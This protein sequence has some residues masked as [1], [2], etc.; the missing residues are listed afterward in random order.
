VV[1]CER[2]VGFGSAC[3]RAVSALDP[4]VEVVCLHNPDATVSA[5]AL[6]ELA[7]RV[8]PDVGAVAPALQ[9]GTVIRNNGYHYPSPPREAYLARRGVRRSDAPLSAGRARRRLPTQD[10]RRFGS[11]ALLVVSRR[12]FE[13]IDGFDERYFMYGEDLDLWHRLELS[14]YEN[15]FCPSVIALHDR[16]TG[17][18]MSRGKREI[19]RW[20]GVELFAQTH[21][22]TGWKPYRIIHRR[23]LSRVDVRSEVGACIADAW[24]QQLPPSDVMALVT[25][26]LQGDA[27][28][29]E[30]AFR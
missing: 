4:S 7:T 2:N 3:N 8:R 14:G 16:S 10:R 15:V 21:L 30:D 26:V 22:R 5:A 9:I 25:P 17:S 24:R 18:P 20:L 19:L 11:G 1:R 23:L 28:D 13:Q 12:A 29:A 27:C 6:R